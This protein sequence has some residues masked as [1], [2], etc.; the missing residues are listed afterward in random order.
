[1]DFAEGYTIVPPTQLT[2]PLARWFPPLNTVS[3]CTGATCDVAVLLDEVQ[4]PLI[5]R[6]N[7]NM[8]YYMGLGAKELL[9]E[10]TFLVKKMGGIA[11]GYHDDFDFIR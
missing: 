11:L 5:F 9:L 10:E 3:Q 2:L 7:H 4:T 1:M 6:T 8:E